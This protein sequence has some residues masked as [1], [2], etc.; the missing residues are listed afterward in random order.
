MLYDTLIS[1]N[2][3]YNNPVLT[4]TNTQYTYR[5]IDA[6]C[7]QIAKT[8]SQYGVHYSDRVVISADQTL[9]TILIILACIRMGV[10]FVPVPP[11]I[12]EDALEFII[13]DAEPALVIS[14]VRY[15][16]SITFVSPEKLINPFADANEP[17]IQTAKDNSIVYILYTSGSTG[18][19][20]GVIAPEESVTFCIHAINLRLQNTSSDRILCCLP[21]SFDYGL[22]Q[23]FLSLAAG[24]CLVLPPQMPL[25][26]IAKYLYVEKITGF[27]AMPSMLNM[28]LRTGLLS[29]VNLSSIRYITSTGDSFPVALIRKIH[30]VIPSASIIPMYG[31]TEC[32]RVSIM[33]LNR[34]DKTL[35]GSCGLP[36]DGVEVWL[37]EKDS[38]GLGELVVSGMNVM[39]GYWRNAIAT[40]QVFFVD[41]Y[42]RRCLRTGDFFRIDEDGFLYFV[43]RKSDILKVNGYRIGAAELEGRLISYMKD[44]VGELG[45][46]GYPD[47]VI[48]DRI[49]VI[50]S[51][52]QSKELVIE[53]L[54]IASARLSI[55]MR[56]HQVCCT[57]E[58]LPKNQNGKIDRK[59]LKKLGYSFVYDKLR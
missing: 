12:S 35:A 57:T 30:D 52:H 15:P 53:W 25:P 6:M 7:F 23:V 40:K 10:C 36:L 8:L 47:E 19:P 55:Y 39:E 33:P 22:Y 37:A 54:R 32:K 14:K 3:D 50:A 38:D 11:N 31:L 27:P 41:E 29:K 13:E 45:V 56:P 20:K 16:S 28:L 34:E 59:R 1:H 2:I 51:T 46:L 26:Q 43:S 44:Y 4:D 24:S 58:P 17:R 48:G 42:G 5:Q 9:N 49:A 21:L 18:T